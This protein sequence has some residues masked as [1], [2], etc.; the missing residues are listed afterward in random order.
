MNY[1]TVALGVMIGGYI[2]VVSYLLACWIKYK[3]EMRK[4]R[5]WREQRKRELFNQPTI[6]DYMKQFSKSWADYSV[7]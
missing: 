4:L 6:D 1:G 5:L 2:G 3:I 7:N